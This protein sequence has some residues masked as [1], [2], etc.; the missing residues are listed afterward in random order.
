MRKTIGSWLASEAWVR[1]LAISSERLA[2]VTQ[3]LSSE[4]WMTA[5]QMRLLLE[6]GNHGVRTPI[7][8]YTTS[9]KSTSTRS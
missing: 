4:I 7:W 6:A 8:G 5:S 9:T 1:S 3:E 2:E